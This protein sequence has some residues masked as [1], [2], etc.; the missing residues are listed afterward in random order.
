MTT[1]SVPATVTRIYSR[2]NVE[3]A[4][5]EVFETVGG[6]SRLARW[7]NEPENYGEYIK[8]LV[9]LIPK[10]AV[11]ELGGAVIE[12]RSMLPPSPLNGPLHEDDILTIEYDDAESES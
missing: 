11:R 5:L 1:R 4:M 6:V 2:K 12:Y 10:D 7:A 9:K 3:Q 8:L